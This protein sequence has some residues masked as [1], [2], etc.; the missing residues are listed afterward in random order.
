MLLT[1]LRV[2]VKDADTVDDLYQETMLIA[3]RRIDDFDR[4]RSFGAWVRGIAK[5]CA[6]DHARRHQRESDIIK[7]SALQYL[8]QNIRRIE[9]RPGDTWSDKLDVLNDCLSHLSQELLETVHYHYR[10]ELPTERIAGLLNASREA[11]KKR[12]QRARKLLHDCLRRKDVFLDHG[13]AQ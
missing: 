13:A 2:L 4:T 7:D 8:E 3:W 1:Y 6:W 9:Q 11:I 12:L 5:R 10:E